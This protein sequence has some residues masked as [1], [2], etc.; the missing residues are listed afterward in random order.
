[1]LML[2]ILQLC[3]VALDETSFRSSVDVVV[4][5]LRQ[6]IV[7]DGTGRL[8]LIN[9]PLHSVRQSHFDGFVI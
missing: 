5:G 1:M 7:D 6:A 9:I 8:P 3:G 2:L 4:E